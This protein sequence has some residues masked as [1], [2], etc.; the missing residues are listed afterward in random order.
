MTGLVFCPLARKWE[1][2]R[3]GGG[4]QG[5]VALGDFGVGVYALLQENGWGGEGVG[6]V[7]INVL[8]QRAP[9]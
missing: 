6:G 5:W 2:T 8:H 9:T 4:E 1:W 3:A 7:Y